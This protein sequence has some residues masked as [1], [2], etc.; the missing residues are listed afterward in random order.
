LQLFFVFH[1]GFIDF[2]NILKNF[3]QS[4]IKI[5]MVAIKNQEKYK[6]TTDFI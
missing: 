3:N 6:E 5:I 4:E 1:I 2:E